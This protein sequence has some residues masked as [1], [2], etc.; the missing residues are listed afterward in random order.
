VAENPQQ[1]VR[2]LR[3]LVIAYAKQ[4]ASD[5]LTGL[6]RYAGFGLAGAVLIGTGV[7]F[8]AI[9][10]LRAMQQYGHRLTHGNFS[11][12]PYIVV[13]IVMAGLAALIWTARSRRQRKVEQRKAERSLSS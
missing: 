1:T 3:E 6:K 9:G 8:L 11:W 2:E 10:A 4:E 12:V 5:P 7:F 13:V